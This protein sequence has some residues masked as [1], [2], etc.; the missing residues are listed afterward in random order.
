MVKKVNDEAECNE[1]L[2]LKAL[3]FT[4]IKHDG[5]YRVGGLPY[6]THPMSVS[7]LV[8]SAGYGIEYR[9]TGLF[10]D[11]LEDTDA[12]E[13]EIRNL[14]GEK[15]LEA[16]KLLTKKKGYIMS[17]Y[18]AGIRS[19]PIAFVVKGADRLHNLRSA[20]DTDEDFRRRYILETIDWYLDFHDAIPMAVKKLSE[21]L[22]TPLAQMNL[23][24]EN[25]D[26]WKLD[27]A[28]ERKESL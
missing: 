13:D 2:F 4:I 26:S 28:F 22:S 15:V 12:T 17:E 25:V 23:L 20:F 27:P 16:V 5:Q 9:I 1:Q 10:H 11:L 8:R 19:N 14:G 6:V 18:V 3:E 21:T 7:E 24:Y